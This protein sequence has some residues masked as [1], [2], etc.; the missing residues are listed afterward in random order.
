MSRLL[1][2]SS[3]PINKLIRPQKKPMTPKSGQ[4]GWVIIKV[5][6]HFPRCKHLKE[7]EPSLKKE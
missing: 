6:L 1:N 4:V 2:V 7:K 3:D 5:I